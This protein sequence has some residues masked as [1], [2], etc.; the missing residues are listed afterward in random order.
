MVVYF[1]GFSTVGNNFGNFTLTDFELVK[2]DLLNHFS[3][4]KGEKLENP[5]FGSII[6]E[7]IY[8]PLDP[9]SK[10]LIIDDITKIAASD[11]RVEVTNVTI[12]EFE[13]G[14]QAE[15]DLRLIPL[16]QVGTIDLVFDTRSASRSS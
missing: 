15:L 13:F 2:R 6:W 7:M 3:I 11:P 10:Q 9:Q 4:R 8:E 5:D 1:K 16:N 14:L 12:S